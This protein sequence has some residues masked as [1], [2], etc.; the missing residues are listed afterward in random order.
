MK[1]EVLRGAV[2]RQGMLLDLVE[3]FFSRRLLNILNFVAKLLMLIAWM[4]LEAFKQ[5]LKIRNIK[6]KLLNTEIDKIITQFTVPVFLLIF[7]Y[8]KLK[9]STKTP[10]KEPKQENETKTLKFKKKHEKKKQRP[11]TNEKTQGKPNQ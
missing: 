9:D 2:L 7:L 3:Y 1:L 5:K 6:R 8:Y 11:E 4:I 10:Q